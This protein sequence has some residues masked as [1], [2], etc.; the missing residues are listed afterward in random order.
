MTKD[1]FVADG[2]TSPWKP[3]SEFREGYALS[4]VVTAKL[5]PAGVPLKVNFRIWMKDTLEP[6]DLF[7]LPL[8]VEVDAIGPVFSEA[9]LQITEKLPKGTRLQMVIV[10]AGDA[11]GIVGEIV[12]R[13]AL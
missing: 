13:V 1:G 3:I 11:E 5:A 8:E 6:A 9:A 4:A 10:Q 12:M 7:E 2:E